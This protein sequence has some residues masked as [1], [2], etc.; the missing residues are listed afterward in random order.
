MLYL[1]SVPVYLVSFTHNANLLTHKNTT[2]KYPWLN[3]VKKKK[4]K[5][6]ELLTDFSS[7]L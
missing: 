6:N 2:L 1:S 3:F 4:K 7:K 5:A